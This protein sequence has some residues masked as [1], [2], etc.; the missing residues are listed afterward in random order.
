MFIF[1]YLL[2]WPVWLALSPTYERLLARAANAVVPLVS[3]G[4]LQHRVTLVD[5]RFYVHVWAK[6]PKTGIKVDAR[7]VDFNWLLMV[8]LLV[9]TRSAGR[10][11]LGSGRAAL[12]VLTLVALH[13]AFLVTLAEYRILR[14]AQV[15]PRLNFALFLF[16]QFYFS[17][18]R[19]GLPILIWMPIGLRLLQSPPSGARG[20]S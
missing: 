4:L 17:V 18:G 6:I 7:S 10:G 1:V 13:V 15:H 9:A 11:A 3:R 12:A 19:I 5:E 2:T 14:D 8:P 20:R 16:D